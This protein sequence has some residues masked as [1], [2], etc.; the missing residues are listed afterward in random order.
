MITT[1]SCTHLKL[2]TEKVLFS[3]FNDGERYVKAKVKNPTVIASFYQPD[4]NL[5]DLL[6][7][8][9]AVKKTKHLLIPYF[10]YARQDKPKPGEANNA[11]AV[12]ELIKTNNIAK[13]SV[14]EMHTKRI[15]NFKF[16]NISS[17]PLFLPSL[18]KLKNTVV[19][20]PDKGAHE[21]AKK[22]A[23]QLKIKTILLKKIRK[24]P[25]QVD[26]KEKKV[27]LQNKTAIIFDDM[28]DTGTTIM[29]TAAIVKKNNAEKIIVCA[30][31]GLFSKNA[32][33]KLEKSP[34]DQIFVSNS[35]PIKN[36]S[37]KIKVIPIEP[38]LKKYI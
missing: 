31:H 33:K 27:N 34:I 20:A 18:K 22:L 35:I 14:V 1:P 17:I 6:L 21:R 2:K 19:I 10:G 23:A 30:A 38:L 3:E 9:N 16:K 28:I 32:I 11:Q 8:L 36:K 12:A 15:K 4:R 7:L 24:R 13:I 26:I 25:G 5:I 37:R 29:K